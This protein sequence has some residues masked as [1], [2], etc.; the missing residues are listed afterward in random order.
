MELNKWEVRNYSVPLSSVTDNNCK[1]L[2][3]INKITSKERQ[4]RNTGL[5]YQNLNKVLIAPVHPGSE[6]LRLPDTKSLAHD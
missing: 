3:T 2:G 4:C 5:K 6:T 1:F